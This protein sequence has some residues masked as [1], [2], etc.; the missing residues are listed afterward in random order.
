[1]VGRVPPT[2]LFGRQNASA[3]QQQ[4]DVRDAL[5][6]DGSQFV[7]LY[8]KMQA[9]I[10][11]LNDTVASLVN[12]IVPSLTYTKAEI[13]TKVASPGNITPGNVT[14]SGQV[15]SAGSPLKSQ[16]SFNYMVATAYKG[17]WIDGATY[18]IGY[19]PSSAVV[20]TDLQP[21]TPGDVEKLLTLTPYWG[22]YLWDAPDSPPKVF[23]L[24]ADVQAAGFGPDVAPVVEDQPLRMVGADGPVLD[25]NG[26]EVIIPV[27]DAY[28]V[29]YSQLVVPLLAAVKGLAA[30]LDA[31]GL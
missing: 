10:A 27:G 16:P 28:S 4:K 11:G 19:S 1:M 25:A 21:L 29:N 18:Q 20:K 13:D 23:F 30:R 2:D 22:R 17:A 14:A 9:L 8:E 24:A 15:D 5:R 26:N 6:I 3:E 31:A 7:R 12:S